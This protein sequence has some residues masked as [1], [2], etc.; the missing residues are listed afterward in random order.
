[1]KLPDFRKMR[2]AMIDSQ[3]RPSGIVEPN[4]I[5]AIKYVPREMYVPAELS[6]LAYLDEALEVVPGRAMPAPLVGCLLMSALEV[7]P[8]ERAL[9]VG[10]TTGYSASILARLCAHVT[11]V[12][13]DATLVRR[14]SSAISKTGVSNVSVVEGPLA[15]GCAEGAPY[16]V[17][18]IDGEVEDVPETLVAQVRDGGRIAAVLAERGAAPSVAVGRVAGG[19]VGWTRLL[20]AGAPRLKGFERPRVFEF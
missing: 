15:E 2:S 11:L 16:D 17:L 12:E 3:L 6:S 5:A 4:L 18:L 1:V 10:G 13:D 14:A 8:T 19:H 9:I 20:E 7:A